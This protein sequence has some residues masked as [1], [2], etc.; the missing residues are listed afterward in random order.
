MPGA[1][2]T[3]MATIAIA[4]LCKNVLSDQVGVA[5]AYCS[6]RLQADQDAL[7]LLTSL[8]RQLVQGRI[9]LAGPVE[10]LYN[11]HR[12]P[13]TRPSLTDISD[14]LKQVCES[15]STTYI[16]MD[17]LDELED[18]DVVRKQVLS[19]ISDLQ[20]RANVRLMVTTRS[21]PAIIQ[22]FKSASRLEVRANRADVENYIAG[23]ISEFPKYVQLLGVKIKEEMSDAVDGM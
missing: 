20:T 6:Y 14:A 15:S 1:G 17:A 13:K 19:R 12:K 16:V 18:R 23:R 2:K 7:S 8:L 5:Y 21:I 11:I 9:L 22:H 4:D 10:R 3:M